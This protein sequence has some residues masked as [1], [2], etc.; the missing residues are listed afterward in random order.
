[1]PR[2]GPPYAAGTARP[3]APASVRVVGCARRRFTRPATPRAEANVRARTSTSGGPAPALPYCPRLACESPG[4]VG[5]DRARGN[6]PSVSRARVSALGCQL[7]PAVSLIGGA[8]CAAGRSL[9]AMKLAFALMA[10]INGSTGSWV[11][12]SHGL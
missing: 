5:R 3:A 2:S 11:T 6:E 10:A 4:V 12:L 9:P 7:W 1:M 8:M